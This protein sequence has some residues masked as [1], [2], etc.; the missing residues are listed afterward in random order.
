MKGWRMLLAAA[1]LAGAVA[2]PRP[3]GAAYLDDAGWGVLTVLSD[4][5]YMP[6]KVVYA[7]LGGLT[8][9]LAFLCT[10]GDFQTAETVWV[11]SMGGTYVI[12]PPMLRGEE[13]ITFAGSPSH[14]AAADTA[15]APASSGMHEQGIGPS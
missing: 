7:T 13:P 9:G 5:V 12:T 4:A 11:T 10:G 2:A 14:D 6:V 15:P 3:A 1:L 8:G